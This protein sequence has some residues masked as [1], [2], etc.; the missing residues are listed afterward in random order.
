MRQ[1]NVLAPI[2]PWRGALTFWR[3]AGA[4]LLAAGAWA[5]WVRFTRGLGAATHL[6]DDFPWGLWIGFDVLVGVGLAAGGFVVAATVHIFRMEKYEPIARPTVLTAFLGYLIVVV[7]LLFDLGRPYRIWHP[8]IMWNPHSVMFEVAWCVTLYTTVLALEFSPMVFERLGWGRPLRI[9]R[10]VYVPLVIIGVLLSTMHQSSLGTLYVIAPDKLHGLW[11]TPLLP[12]FFFITAIAVGLAMTIFESFMS[13]RAF[14][15]RLEP[16]VLDGLARAIVVV[17][18]V[19]AVWKLEDLLVRGQLGLAAQ[20]TPESVLFWGE[21]GLGVA[22]PMLLFAW[23]RTRRDPHFLFFA[24]V[25]TVMGFV[26]NRMNVAVTGMQGWART[27]YFPSIYEL[28]VTIALVVAGFALFGAAVKH[29]PVFPAGDPHRE[30]ESTAGRNP[31]WASATPA[32]PAPAFRGR[33]L[34][35]LWILLGIGAAGVL[36]I[37]P[38]PDAAPRPDLGSSPAARPAGGGSELRLP[39]EHRFPTSSESP[40]AVTF[41]HES[42]VDPDAPDCTRCHAAAWSLLEP[43]KPL[44]GAVTGDRMHDELCGSCHDGTRAFAVSDACDACH[45]PAGR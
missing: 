39:V 20:L 45:E 24:A 29:L 16:H 34:V 5:A 15:K 43:G 38:R 8:L 42:H 14:G 4:L 19:Y 31:G 33:V 23:P 17:L 25:L 30:P 36:F 41:R 27:P 9:M 22:L 11:Y 12:V 2:G 35:A 28:A 7:A 37:A 32:V 21:V 10:A 1:R 6:S 3:L 40:G 26:I 13:Y 18:G 44:A